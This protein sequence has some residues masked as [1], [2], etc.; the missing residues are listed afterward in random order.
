MR[1]TQPL[2]HLDVAAS[3]A[4]MVDRRGDRRFLQGPDP[5]L[6]RVVPDLQ[7]RDEIHK[8]SKAAGEHHA[9]ACKV[10]FGSVLIQIALLD[11]I[12][13]LDSVITAVGMVKAEG[14]DLWGWP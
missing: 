5:V 2:F 1:L 4:R 13:S 7:E 6:R 11:M 14:D 8:G 10:S 12:F 3:A 9:V